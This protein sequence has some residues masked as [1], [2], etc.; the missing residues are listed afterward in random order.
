MY[1]VYRKYS[2]IV[3]L[4]V[5]IHVHTLIWDIYEEAD[6]DFSDKPR[7]GRP[8]FIDNDIIKIMIEQDPLLSISEIAEKLSLTQQTI[9]DHIRKLRLVFSSLE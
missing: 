4:Q 5:S 3:S 1:E 7:S 2:P 9:S 8:F 6:L